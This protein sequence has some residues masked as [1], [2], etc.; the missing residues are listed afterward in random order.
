M[1]WTK[2]Q[3]IAYDAFLWSEEIRHQE[4]IIKIQ[5]K[6]KALHKKGFIA[7]EPGPWI[8]TK[9]IEEI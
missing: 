6:R 7:S 4:D 1:K 2:D 9:E 8:E 5:E 3:L